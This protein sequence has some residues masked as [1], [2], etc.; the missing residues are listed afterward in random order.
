MN[1]QIYKNWR[2]DVGTDYETTRKLVDEDYTR[3]DISRNTENELV[4]MNEKLTGA[5]T[6]NEQPEALRLADELEN[7]ECFDVGATGVAYGWMHN[8]PTS[9]SADELRRLHK[10]NKRLR[11]EVRVLR[12]YGN[13]D[14]TSMADEVLKQ[15][16]TR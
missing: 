13:K 15:E 4:K 14:C 3:A 16:Q 7:G 9:E 1:D 11:E 6:M 5:T 2:K 10:E 8:D 12:L